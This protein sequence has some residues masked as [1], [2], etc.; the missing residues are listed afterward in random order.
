MSTVYL[1]QKSREMF[2]KSN[3]IE[4]KLFDPGD[5]N[6]NSIYPDG[7]TPLE[8]QVA[9]HSVADGKSTIGMLRHKDGYVL[10][11]LIKPVQAQ[12]ELKFYEELQV[13]TDQASIELRRFVPEYFGTT[14]LSIGDK[15]V[16]F[17]V[18]KNATQGFSEPCVMDIKIGKQTWDPDATKEKIEGEKQKYTE[19]KEELGFCIPGFQVHRLST[20]KIIKLG[21]EYGKRLN[22]STVRDAL[23][24]FLNSDSGLS[25]ELVIQF[26]ASLWKIMGWCRRQRRFRI[27]SSSLLLVY[28]AKKLRQSLNSDAINR[29]VSSKP[30]RPLTIKISNGTCNGAP[31]SPGFGSSGGYS[32]PQSPDQL[33]ATGTIMEKPR[34]STSSS[35]GSLSPSVL[36]AP[37]T[38]TS[39]FQRQSNSVFGQDSW[40]KMYD[41]IRRTHSFIHNYE[42]DLQSMK[43]SY[44]YQLDHLIS[45]DNPGGN[46][47]WA[48]IKMIDFAHIF[49]APTDEPDMNYLEG[50][51]NLVKLFESLMSE[52]L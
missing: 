12:R 50:L 37:T 13:A 9:G 42:K 3:G 29:P 4:S 49:P 21:K 40:H 51:E 27:Y 36:S 14:T 15:D 34:T 17:L 7:T 23:K 26:L 38:P 35:C 1:R 47:A 18:L 28:D 48:S 32:T 52:A 44:M 33:S 6:R 45:A 19:C 43:E 11:P 10:K 39:P 5:E 25:R 8:N 20:G 31:L 2:P 22:K 41:K 16:E 24:L 30:S 46:D